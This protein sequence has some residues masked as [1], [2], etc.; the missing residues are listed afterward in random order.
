MITLKRR[1]EDGL[2]SLEM[3]QYL[4]LHARDVDFATT[5]LKARQFADTTDMAKP[6]KSVKF[7]QLDHNHAPSDSPPADGLQA[8][9][10][11][12]RTDNEEIFHSFI[13]LVISVCAPFVK[14]QPT[15]WSVTSQGQYQS[16]TTWYHSPVTFTLSRATDNA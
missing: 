10:G 2:Q 16:T 5:V 3:S 12:L 7:V 1:F 13:S 4:R 9:A 14:Q 15:F 8:S 11:R 6:K